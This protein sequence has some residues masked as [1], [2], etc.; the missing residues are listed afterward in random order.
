MVLFVK[1]CKFT[2][3]ERSSLVQRCSVSITTTSLS[4][5]VELFIFFITF[6]KNFLVVA[7][8][9]LAHAFPV[10][11]SNCISDDNSFWK[12]CTMCRASPAPA[13]ASPYGVMIC[14]RRRFAPASPNALKI[15]PAPIFS[16]SRYCTILSTISFLSLSLQ[17]IASVLEK[18]S[19]L[20]PS[21]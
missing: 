6:I 9:Q 15:S 1:V 20:K 10:Y 18:S 17:T 5:I 12:I 11:C 19:L 13:F 3:L 8:I 14:G 2:I 16:V 4:I 7:R 21:K